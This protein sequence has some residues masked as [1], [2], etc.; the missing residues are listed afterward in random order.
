MGSKPTV[1]LSAGGG[2]FASYGY[3][4]ECSGLGSGDGGGVTECSG[5]GAF[6]EGNNWG[7]FG[8]EGVDRAGG[9]KL[10]GG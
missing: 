8:S 10:P 1:E 3:G 9:A 2:D 4:C 6:G 7:G 5:G